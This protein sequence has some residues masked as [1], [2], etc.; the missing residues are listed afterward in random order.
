MAT[1]ITGGAYTSALELQ[2]DSG[3]VRR[4]PTT[5]DTA[6]SNVIVENDAELSGVAKALG[7]LD[8]LSQADPARFRQLTACVSETL[9]SLAAQNNGSESDALKQI[10][11]WFQDA[12]VHGSTAPL[13]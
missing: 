12:S 4:A 3:G 10:S 8:N 13:L 11:G 6:G 9:G 1:A 2:Q 7:S 5:Q